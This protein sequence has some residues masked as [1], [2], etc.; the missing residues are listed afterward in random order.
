[1]MFLKS[2][3]FV[4]FLL[5]VFKIDNVC[6]RNL[7]GEDNIVVGYGNGMDQVSCDSTTNISCG[8]RETIH[9]GEHV[10]SRLPQG[11]SDD[12]RGELEDYIKKSLMQQFPQLNL[13][14]IA[15][16][17][18]QIIGLIINFLSNGSMMVEGVSR[19]S[20]NIYKGGVR[21]DAIEHV[22]IGGN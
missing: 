3:V 13:A 7:I 20:S 22:I 16:I 17:V 5:F 1:M 18:Q 11:L 9:Q 4:F 21:G 2:I 19:N 12:F 15:P 8:V 10:E 14:L 6:C